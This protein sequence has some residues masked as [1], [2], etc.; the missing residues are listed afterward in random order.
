MFRIWV[1]GLVG[2]KLRLKTFN[3]NLLKWVSQN[4][5]KQMIEVPIYVILMN[6]QLNFINGIVKHFA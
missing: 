6:L 3:L 1:L 2:G 4:C 5:A